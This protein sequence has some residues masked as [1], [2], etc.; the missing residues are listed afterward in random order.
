MLKK[1]KEKEKKQRKHLSLRQT[2]P[3]VKKGEFH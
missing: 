2:F 1:E 3:L